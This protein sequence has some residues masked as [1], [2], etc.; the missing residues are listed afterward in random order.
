MSE[1]AYVLINAVK[2]KV[3]EMLAMLSKSPGIISADSVDGPPEIIMIVEA[4]D[5][6]KLAR[7]VSNALYSIENMTDDLCCLPINTK[8]S[9]L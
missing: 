8:N 5:R 2:G 7:L 4:D 9:T 1:R 6:L 3:P